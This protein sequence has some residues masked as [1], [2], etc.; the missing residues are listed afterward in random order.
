MT[1]SHLGWGWEVDSEKVR[2]SYGT[3]SGDHQISVQC[4][5]QDVNGSP[6]IAK[7][8][9]TA[10]ITVTPLLDGLVGQ[11]MSFSSELTVFVIVVVVVLSLLHIK[12]KSHES[13]LQLFSMKLHFCQSL[14]FFNHMIKNKTKKQ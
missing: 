10:A 11:P 2:D 12:K 9:N 6:F 3:I 7:A 14:D 4:S 5:G 8:Y 1:V 13:W